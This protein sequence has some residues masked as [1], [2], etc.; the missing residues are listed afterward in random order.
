MTTK[1]K[2]KVKPLPLPLPKNAVKVEK[3][4]AARYYVIERNSRDLEAFETLDEALDYITENC[5]PYYDGEIP[6]KG[7]LAIVY[8]EQVSFSYETKV[9]AKK[10]GA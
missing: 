3:K 5:I 1:K 2:K 9:L 4:T 7:D 6:S 8:G 10:S